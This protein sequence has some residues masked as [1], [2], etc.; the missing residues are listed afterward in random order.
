M[1]SEEGVQL[2]LPNKLKPIIGNPIVVTEASTALLTSPEARDREV[3]IKDDT[4]NLVDIN[5]N[6]EQFRCN[7]CDEF[8]RS[9][10]SL[11]GHISR[12]H[13]KSSA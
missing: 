1:E 7:Q 9:A 4:F 13:P 11:G 8:F 12:K 2:N 5:E 3:K 6:Q 10:Q